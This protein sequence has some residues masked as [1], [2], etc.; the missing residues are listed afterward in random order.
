MLSEE[1]PIPSVYWMPR[2]EAADH[3][4]QYADRIATFNAAAKAK[5]QQIAVEMLKPSSAGVLQV[6]VATPRGCSFGRL[7]PG[8]LEGLNKQGASNNAIHARKQLV[9]SQIGFVRE[10]LD[11]WQ[12]DGKDLEDAVVLIADPADPRAATAAHVLNAVISKMTSDNDFFNG[13]PIV[14]ASP[15]PKTKVLFEKIR[16][17]IFQWLDVLPAPGSTR[18]VCLAYGGETCMHGKV[19][20]K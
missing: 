17:K 11:N 14:V 1:A 5:L 2:S 16:P 9:Q 15:I 20:A 8:A 3:T 6:S 10:C 7:D 13:Q 12:A 18:V 19:I 4:L